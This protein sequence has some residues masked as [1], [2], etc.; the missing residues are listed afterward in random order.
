[1]SDPR[2]YAEINRSLLVL[3]P[4]VEQPVSIKMAII[5]LL[6][7]LDTGLVL[8]ALSVFSAGPNNGIGPGISTKIPRHL[9]LLLLRET[10][11]FNSM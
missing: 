11:L 10:S 4:K 8:S 5:L 6:F 3:I 7:V 2:Q 9:I 1:M